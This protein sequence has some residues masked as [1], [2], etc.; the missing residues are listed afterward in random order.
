MSHLD[1][2]VEVKPTYMPLFSVIQ[3]SKVHLD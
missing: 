3:S 1:R 2:V